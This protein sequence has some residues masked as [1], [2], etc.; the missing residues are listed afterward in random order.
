MKSRPNIVMLCCHDIG[1][2]ITPYG[3]NTVVTPNIQALADDGVVFENN[4][5]TS[6]GCSP[7]RAAMM[8]GRY[9]HSN[10][11]MG[12]ANPLSKW[13]LHA[14][15][16]HLASYLKD[17]GYQTC[18]IGNWHED[19]RDGKTLK[20]LGY[21]LSVCN[22][23]DSLTVT[24]NPDDN[25]LMARADEVAAKVKCYLDVKES[26]QPFFLYAGFYEPHRPWG[27]KGSQP[28]VSRGV[29]IPPYI[30][31]E[32][33]E[34]IAAAEGEFAE[35]QGMIASLDRA[36]GDI[37]DALR[38]RNMLED[39]VIIFTSDHGV[40][41]PRAK[42]SLYDPGI[43]IPFIVSGE[44]WVKD[45]GRRVEHLASNVDYLPTIL[46]ALDIPAPDNLH[47]RS[48]FSLLQGGNEEVNDFIYAE[49]NYHKCYDPIRCIRSKR[50]KYIINF[51]MNSSYEAPG[52]IQKGV[53]YQVN[54]AKYMEHRPPLEL[55]DLDNDPWEQENLAGHDDCIEV[56]SE[57]HEK[58]F[59]W[60]HKTNDPLLKGPI[61]SN[62]FE[63]VIA[64]EML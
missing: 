56:Q 61:R 2:H 34:Q 60:M 46:E 29:Y 18:V 37:V 30:P 55:Y 11:M 16:K 33:P 24:D 43:E 1:Q 42:C 12:L 21:D 58:L 52:D 47:G 22:A 6:P 59:Q 19:T 26:D 54:A 7:S 17:N 57:L 14:D 48:L 53:I 45:P 62:Y 41:M 40:A 8:T 10:G 64:S 4:F 13:K 36:I 38:Q 50:Y 44:H 28:D 63:E 23:G 9:S 5:C 20:R 3:I 25:D 39:S 32:T 31:Q 27:W 15:E 35:I 49:K 51:E